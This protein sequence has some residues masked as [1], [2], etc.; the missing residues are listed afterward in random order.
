MDLDAIAAAAA[1]LVLGSCCVG[2][3]HP[4]PVLCAGC[5][6]VFEDLPVRTWPDPCPEGLPPVWALTAYDGVARVALV[7]HKEHAQLALTRPLGRAL[8]VAAMGLLASTPGRGDGVRLVPVPSRPAVVRERGH[9][10]LARLAQAAARSLR[11]AGIAATVSKA[12]RQRRDVADQAGLGAA[13][14]GTNLV[15]AFAGRPRDRTGPDDSWIVVDDIVTTGATAVEASRALAAAGV[16]VLGVAV[17]A[18]TQ[19]HTPAGV[20]ED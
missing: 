8:A 7:A 16:P 6:R 14:R 2:C 10:P 15:G 20:G 3:E 13:E 9:D 19:R 12:L 17:I 18:A 11:R 5:E 1:D 4:G